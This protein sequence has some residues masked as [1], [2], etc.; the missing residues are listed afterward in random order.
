MPLS[1]RFRALALVLFAFAS[2]AFAQW[3]PVAGVP[4]TNIFSLF[5]KGDTILAG[6]DTTVYLSTD[7]GGTWTRSSKPV[8]SVTSIEAVHV[9]N[10][11]LYAGTFG[12]GVFVSDDRGLTWQGYNQGLV[13][14]FFDSQ[15]DLGDFAVRG[16]SL[17]AATLGAG[18]YVRKLTGV[19]AWSHFGEEFEPNQASAV[20][21][22]ALGGSRLIASAGNNG[23]V[24]LR[25]PGTPEWTDS[26]L[27][28][29][30]LTPGLQAFNAAFNGHGWVVG[31]NVGTFRSS[32]GQEPWAFTNPGLGGLF[33]VG[34]ATIGAEFFAAF[35]IANFALTEHSSDDGASWQVLDVTPNAFVFRL[36]ASHGV[37]F[38]ARTDGLW[39]R[40]NDGLSTPIAGSPGHVEFAL[41]GAQPV[42]EQARF[43]FT[44]VH[45]GRASIELYDI[46]GRQAAPRIE[47]TWPA[48]PQELAWDARGLEPG[49]YQALLRTDDARAVVKLVRV[50]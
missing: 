10:G 21:G 45:A 2:P 38:A 19:T 17:Y 36:V 9:R 32:L 14:G 34:L 41:A 5:A 1:S 28:N 31:T 4:A 8:A 29:A 7:A 43:R 47:G 20:N 39:R 50:R 24:F 22:L 25:D 3:A 15:L 44:L 49:V 33:N 16:D 35:S 13:G 30:G 23:M 40:T 42:R 37:L 18:V 27:D 12:Q 48:G 6:A 26:F 11:R 46:A